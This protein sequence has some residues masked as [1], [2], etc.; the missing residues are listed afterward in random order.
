MILLG[1]ALATTPWERTGELR[2]RDADALV[3]PDVT[4]RAELGALVRDLVRAAPSGAVPAGL[5]ERASALGL[6]LDVSDGIALLGSNA[7]WGLLA[8]RLGPASPW[9]VQAPHPWFD[10]GTG[11][12]TGL[13]FAESDARAAL[14]ATTHR[15]LAD[16]TDAAHQAEG[17]FQ[18]LTLALVD[19][20]EDP[21]LVQIHGF[22]GGH[23]GAD[24]VVGGW[25]AASL[26][27]GLTTLGW[28][29]ADGK[30]VPSLAGSTNLQVRA[31]AGRAP[32]AHLE[33]N[34]ATRTALR[35]D[36]ALRARLWA[37]LKAWAR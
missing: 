21:V 35:D 19:A 5:P 2:V 36:P 17:G 6:S 29:A 22:G 10:L 27:E 16:T 13:L 33:L 12:L 26:T 14:F 20:L 34:K 9:V 23:T 32:V 4:Q 3:V 11:E 1:L 31:L 24:V 30:A 8:V 28:V 7:G 37:V 18:T 15:K 25:G